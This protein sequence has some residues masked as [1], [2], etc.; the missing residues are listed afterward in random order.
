MQ[1]PFVDLKAQYESIK[2][3]VSPN[4]L[5]IKLE[6]KE[7][8]LQQKEKELQQLKIATDTVNNEANKYDSITTK[9]KTSERPHITTQQKSTPKYQYKGSQPETEQNKGN[10]KFK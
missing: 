7:K 2:E 6:Q 5:K 9:S 1:I 8:E 3:E 10:T 4:D